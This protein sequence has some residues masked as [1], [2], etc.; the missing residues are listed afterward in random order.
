MI[1]KMSVYAVEVGSSSRLYTEGCIPVMSPQASCTIEFDPVSVVK[2]DGDLFYTDKC[3]T[4]T[5]SPHNVTGKT[6]HFNQCRLSDGSSEV[7]YTLFGELSDAVGS[8]LATQ[9]HC[10]LSAEEAGECWKQADAAIQYG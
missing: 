2:Q 5:T 9:L 7:Y 1:K 10:R 6:V 3:H 8:Y 4:P